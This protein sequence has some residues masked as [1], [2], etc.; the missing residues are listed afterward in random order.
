MKIIRTI[1]SRPASRHSLIGLGNFDGV[2]IGHRTI[3]KKL[4]DEAAAQQGTAL[5]MTFHPH[6]LTVLRPDRPVSLILSL[7]EKLQ[8]ITAMGVDGIILQRFELGFARLT[9]EEFIQ[10]YLVEA[11]GVEKVIVG[12]NVSFGRDRAGNAE[13][14]VALG[15]QSGFE[16]E[17]VGPVTLG[18]RAVSS[19]AVRSL[20]KAGNMRETTQLLGQPYALSGRV[21]KGFQR[22]REIGFPTAN[23]RPRAPVLLPNGVY[24]VCVDVGDD[25]YPGVANV[26]V[27]PTFGENQRTIET[28]LFDFSAD[29]YGKR[30]RVAFVERLREERKFP[31]VQD[32]VSQIR[33]DAHRARTLLSIAGQS[34]L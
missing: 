30:I 17:V 3:L 13:R 12:H 26:G 2:H 1:L 22:G 5:V 10:R 29:L 11:I 7:R 6:P 34:G 19:T 8:R 9:P 16:V 32:L 27:N 33:E 14:L 28:H 24:A 25:Q 20:L 21:V 18:N 31:S 23:L 15:E 4:V